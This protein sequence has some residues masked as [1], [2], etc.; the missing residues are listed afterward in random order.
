MITGYN[1]SAVAA[2]N[3]LPLKRQIRKPRFGGNRFIFAATK[4]DG[5]FAPTGSGSQRQDRQDKLLL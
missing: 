5:S 4:S 2:A 1:K 3:V